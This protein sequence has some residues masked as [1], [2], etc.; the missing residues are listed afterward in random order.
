MSANLGGAHFEFAF[1]GKPRSSFAVELHFKK[2]TKS[3][4]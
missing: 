4:T 1:H 3:L 2:M